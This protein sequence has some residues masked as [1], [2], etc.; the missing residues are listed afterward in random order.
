MIGFISFSSSNIKGSVYPACSPV[1]VLLVLLPIAILTGVRR[2][3]KGVL[4]SMSLI[5]QDIELFF[6]I[7]F[8]ATYT[9][10]DYLSIS[11]SHLLIGLS[12]AWGLD[13]EVTMSW[14][15]FRC[16]ASKLVASV[17]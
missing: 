5:V 2:C 9:L 6:F 10:G 12:V 13:F 7:Y 16:V 1:L 15:L 3:L 8:L 14:I 4:I 17:L 11:L